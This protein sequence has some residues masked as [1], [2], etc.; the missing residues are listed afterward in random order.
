MQAKGEMLGNTIN[1][2]VEELKK[3][4]TGQADQVAENIHI[5]Q[6]T[7]S[8]PYD[9]ITKVKDEEAEDQEQESRSSSSKQ[10]Y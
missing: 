1:D 10:R 7:I 4:C 3:M 8:E 6:V 2:L 9:L 5:P